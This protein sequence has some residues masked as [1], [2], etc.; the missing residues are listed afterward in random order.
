MERVG[1]EEN[2]FEL[3][4][5]S[6]LVTQVVSRIR[7]SLNVE[8]PV[9]AVFEYPTV[10]ALG[11]QVEAESRGG[12]EAP[13]P[14]VRRE[15]VEASAAFVRAER[16]WFLDQFEPGSSA[17]NMPFALRLKGALVVAALE[18]AMTE[19]VRRHEV[20]RTRFAVEEGEPVQ[21]VDEPAPFRVASGPSQ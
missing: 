19:V 15:S 2:F 18:R 9:R 8:L 11:A 20:L 7:E 12:R 17:Y 21:V 3:G 10:A 4:G 1:V 16:L 14:L 5:H 13:P 6:L